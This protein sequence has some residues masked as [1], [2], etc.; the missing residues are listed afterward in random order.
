MTVE[1]GSQI[2][3]LSD[4][5]YFSGSHASTTFLSG[6]KIITNAPDPIDVVPA[7]SGDTLI[8]NP[9]RIQEL[10][11]WAHAHPGRKTDFEYDCSNLILFAYRLP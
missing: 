3:L 6:Q 5:T 8:A 2:Y 9:N 10:E 11:A 4:D 7:V 1:P